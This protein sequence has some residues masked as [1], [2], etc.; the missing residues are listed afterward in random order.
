MWDR[1]DLELLQRVKTVTPYRS[2]NADKLLETAERHITKRL[3]NATLRAS[4]R[5]LFSIS[6]GRNSN[7]IILYVTTILLVFFSMTFGFNIIGLVGLDVAVKVAWSVI[8][9]S[10]GI[11]G[12]SIITS[13]GYE[14]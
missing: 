1:R 2:E 9:L 5:R 14:I 6:L 7:S 13:W 8:G 3:G 12:W 11:R 10:G 4:K